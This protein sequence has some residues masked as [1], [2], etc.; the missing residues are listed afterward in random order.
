[1]KEKKFEQQQINATVIEV[2]NSIDIEIGYGHYISAYPLYKCNARVHESNEM[3]ILESY[4]TY[5]A[6]YIKDVGFVYD[7]LRYAF[8]YTS[9]SAQHYRKFKAWLTE[10]GYEINGECRYYDI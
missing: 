1:M 10:H 4:S 9:T 5:T 3:F 2:M 6:A 8:G 7:G